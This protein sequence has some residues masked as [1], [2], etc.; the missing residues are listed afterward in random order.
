MG[1]GG[2]LH[3]RTWKMGGLGQNIVPKTLH[4]SVGYVLSARVSQAS[5]CTLG[6]IVETWHVLVGGS[7][8]VLIS[9]LMFRGLWFST[10]QNEHWVVI[11]TWHV[12]MLVCSRVPLV[13]VWKPVLGCLEVS[14]VF[15]IR[16]WN[17]VRVNDRGHQE[18]A[19][20]CVGKMLVTLEKS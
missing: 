1:H 12:F 19:Q 5:K 16:R 18:D 2:G 9:R 14:E 4:V 10:S 11:E 7:F 17:N 3:G 6:Y 15:T 8:E 13:H 20:R